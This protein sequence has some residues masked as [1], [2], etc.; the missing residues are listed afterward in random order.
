VF[1]NARLYCSA[2]MDSKKIRFFTKG[3][4]FTGL[5]CLDHLQWF[6]KNPYFLNK[7]E[8]KKYN[9]Y[10]SRFAKQSQNIQICNLFVINRICVVAAIF[11][12]SS[13]LIS[14]AGSDN[15]ADRTD[16]YAYLENK[17]KKK[18]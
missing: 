14:E 16:I 11:F 7:K 1:P 4:P 9:L 5:T 15:L 17:K 3:V 18:I 8:K 13:W 12:E 6:P 10:L 2:K